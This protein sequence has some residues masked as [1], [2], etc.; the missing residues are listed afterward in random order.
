MVHFGCPSSAR[1]KPR[2]GFKKGAAV[3]EWSWTETCRV[4]E[5]K[6]SANED[7]PCREGVDIKLIAIDRLTSKTF[8]G[9]HLKIIS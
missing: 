3:A 4:S 7:Q 8:W 6:P 1:G 2:R 9:D 5:L